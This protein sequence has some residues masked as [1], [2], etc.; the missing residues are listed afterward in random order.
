MPRSARDQRVFI[1]ANPDKPGA[2]SA[3]ENLKRFADRRCT[4]VGSIS[5]HDGRS[6]LEHQ[7]NRIIVLGGDGTLIGVAR[8]LGAQ[9]VPLIGVNIGKLGFLTEFSIDELQKCFDRAVLDDGLVDPRMVLEVKVTRAGQCAAHFLAINDAVIQ[10][11]PPFRIIGLGVIVNDEHITVVAGDG[12]IL[13]TPGGST[14][15]NLSAGGPIMQPGIAAIILTPLNP[16]SL[17]LRPIVIESDATVDVQALH[18]NEGTALIIDGQVRYA[19]RDGDRLNVKRFE[20]DCKIVRNP[21]HN[22][23]HKLVSKLHWGRGPNLN[24]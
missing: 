17:T 10:A 2:A 21:A 11:G 4:I 22:T 23:W 14:G 15:H 13:C 19:L 5:G 6:A 12:I 3:L 18:V 9:Q 16:H 7:P 8:T 24:P 1:V 20:T